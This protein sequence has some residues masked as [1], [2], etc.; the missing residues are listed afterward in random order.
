LTGKKLKIGKDW[1]NPTNKYH[2]GM[3]RVYELFPKE[4]A[5]RL[6]KDA[7]KDFTK[8]Q[9]EWIIKL[10]REIQNAKGDEKKSWSCVWNS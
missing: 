5:S 4:L 8:Q 6:E 3:K 1:K 7:K 2:I 10:N 9:D